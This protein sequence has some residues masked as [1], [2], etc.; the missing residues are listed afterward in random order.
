MKA[1]KL[2]LILLLTM[3][4]GISTLCAQNEKEQQAEMVKMIISSKSY[5]IDVD[6]YL[7]PYSD[8]KLLSYS[9]YAIEIKNDSVFSHLLYLSHTDIRYNIGLELNFQ[10]PLKKYAMNRDKKG[11]IHIKFSTHTTTDSLYFMIEVYPNGRTSIYVTMRRGQSIRFSG[12]LN[13]Q[14]E[15]AKR[16]VIQ[17]L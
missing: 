3:L 13:T 2:I 15:K 14:I 10:A 7:E 8:P 4:P 17:C 9:D 16:K 6:T 12:E 5:K 11:N 1:K